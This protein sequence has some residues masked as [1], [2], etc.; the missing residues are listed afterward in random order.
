MEI[1][2]FDVPNGRKQFINAQPDSYANKLLVDLSKENP[3]PLE[4]MGLDG[5]TYVKYIAGEVSQTPKGFPERLIATTLV[6]P[7]PG[8]L[9]AVAKDLCLELNN[10]PY[11]Q[12]INVEVDEATFLS[13]GTFFDIIGTGQAFTLFKAVYPEASS[14]PNWGLAN[15][16]K[17]CAFFNKGSFPANAVPIMGVPVAW[18]VDAAQ[19]E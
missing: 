2:V 15:E 18:T 6:D 9:L 10:S 3:P 13:S 5:K 12:R 8:P 1:R 17:A 11:N 14:T 19:E 4:D 7:A 16:A